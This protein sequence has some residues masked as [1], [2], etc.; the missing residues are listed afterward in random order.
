MVRAAA[1]KTIISED[2]THGEEPA[3]SGTYNVARYFALRRDDMRVG[4]MIDFYAVL[5]SWRF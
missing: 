2:L 3:H 4:E 1:Y 5:V